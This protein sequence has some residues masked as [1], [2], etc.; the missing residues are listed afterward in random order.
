M[1]IVTK[2]LTSDL[3]PE[4]EELF[5]PNGACGGCWCMAWRVAKGEKW[6]DLKGAPAKRR[7]RRMV[8]A[9]TVHGILAFV[10]GSPVGW[11]NF[12]PR[13]DFSKLNRAPSFRCEDAEQVWSIP[14][15]F[16]KRGYRGKG[17]AGAMLTHA[18]RAIKARG[19]KIAEGYPSKPDKN[20][21]YIDTFAWTGT[22]SLFAKRGFVVVANRD[23]GKQRVRKTLSR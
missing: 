20:G 15:F 13:P 7:L 22:R 10:D 16:V 9:E 23:G 6:D 21:K 4:V 8:R 12:G 2:E 3:W 14:C 17:V 5:G 18:L 19:G 1:K 11:C